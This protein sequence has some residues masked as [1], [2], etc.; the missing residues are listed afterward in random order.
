MTDTLL[1]LG[2]STRA[3]AFSAIRAGMR[4]ICGDMFADADLRQVADILEV[5]DFPRKLRLA[6]QSVP[7]WPW[8]YTGALENSPS[9]IHAVSQRHRL[10][11]NEATVLRSCRDPWNIQRIIEQAE[12]PTLELRTSEYAPPRDGNWIIKPYRSAAGRNMARWEDQ[13]SAPQEA[14]YFQRFQSGCPISAAFLGLSPQ[15]D[16]SSA[17]LLGVST[18][19]IGS[20][21]L[22]APKFGYCGSIVPSQIDDLNEISLPFL[23]HKPIRPRPAEPNLTQ[24]LAQ[25]GQA[26]ARKCH[27]RGLFGIDFI[28]DGN[29]AWIL[30]VNP[31][32]TA[33]MELVECTLNRPL[34]DWHR[35]ACLATPSPDLVQ[36]IRAEIRE[37][38]L[39]AARHREFFGKVVLYAD[40]NSI[41]PDLSE[42]LNAEIK[43]GCLPQIADIPINGSPILKCQP[44]FTCLGRNA[45]PTQLLSNL[46]ER[47]HTL[48]N[49]FP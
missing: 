4:P 41:T 28:W 11:G 33:S 29:Q 31:R 35:R 24:L 49:R 25:A 19:L 45:E 46:I 15:P 10:L 40:R 1:I 6:T 34:L 44:V 39:F 13:A 48:W 7:S 8:I 47:A 37:S 12:L 36:T 16:Q 23:C 30:E 27:L 21:R 5:P 38:H 14:H 32:Y 26:I 22:N 42:F 43:L 18:Q 3:A 17:E 9:Q 2:A 20:P